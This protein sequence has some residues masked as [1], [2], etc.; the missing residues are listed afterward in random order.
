MREKY[1]V[2][3]IDNEGNSEEPHVEQSTNKP[4][5][6]LLYRRPDPTIEA[7]EAMEALQALNGLCCVLCLYVLCRECC[8]VDSMPFNDEH[9]F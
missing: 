8:Q 4:Q 9:K 6:M 2:K 3:V 7:I 5:Q 1:N